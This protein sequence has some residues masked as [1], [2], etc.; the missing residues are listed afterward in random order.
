MANSYRTRET[1]LKKIKTHS[2]EHSWDE[3]INYYKGYIYIVARNMNLKHHDAE[4]ILQRVLIRLWEKLPEF[5]YSPNKGSFRAFLCTI[6]RNMI[7]DLL[8]KRKRIFSTSEDIKELELKPK[9]EPFS[10]AEVEQI[11]EREWKIYIA[12]TAWQEIKGEL[13]DNVRKT[14]L[15]LL[16]GYDVDEISIELGI[17]RN[18]VYVYKLRVLEK[19]QR[20]IRALEERFS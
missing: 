18:T 17:Q 11:A 10:L 14:Y 2:D 20:K 6:I 8:K 3:F 9:S 15:L 4:D 12:N 16:A 13:T 1:L 5:D 7:I 19:F